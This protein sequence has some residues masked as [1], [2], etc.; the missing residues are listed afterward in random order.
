MELSKRAIFVDISRSHK[1]L[2]DL[3]LQIYIELSSRRLNH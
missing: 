3:A 1:P 2:D